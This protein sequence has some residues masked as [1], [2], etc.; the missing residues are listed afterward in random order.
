MNCPKCQNEMMELNEASFSAAKCSG[1]SGIWFR[2]GGHEVAKSIKGIS[3]IDEVDT[4]AA[5]VYNQVRNVQC[6]ECQQPLIKMVDST[7]LHIEFESCA[8]GCG[9]FFDAGEFKDFTEFTFMER[10]GQ[11]IETIKTNLK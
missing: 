9:I 1:C 7:Q 11:T 10:V 4:N 6:P 8:D 3:S 2:D 5:A